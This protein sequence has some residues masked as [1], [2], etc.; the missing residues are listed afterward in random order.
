MVSIPGYSI[1]EELYNGSRTQVYRA[2]RDDQNICS[3]QTTEKYSS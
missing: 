3:Y 2:V 1:I